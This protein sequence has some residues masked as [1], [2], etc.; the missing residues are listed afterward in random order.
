MRRSDLLAALAVA[1]LSLLVTVPRA[2]AYPFWQ[3]EVGAARVMVEP[4]LVEMLRGVV[5]TE[6]HPPGFYTFGWI[7]NGL[8]VPV[9][10]ARA[11]SVAAVAV[12]AAGVVL[13]ARRLMPLPFAALAGLAVALGWQFERHGWELRPYGLF[14]LV[15]FAAV[16]AL[17]WAARE[18]TLRRRVVLA[19]IVAVGSLVH[20]F[21]VFTLAAGVLWLFLSR[22]RERRAL[23][24]TIAVGL[25]P[26]AA[27][28]PAFVEQ[29]RKEHFAT[30]PSFH[31]RGVVD[32]YAD[33]LER[34]L[35]AG[36]LGLLVALAVLA[37]V[38]VGAV[39]LWA[40]PWRGRLCALA[41]LL[42]VAVAAAIWLGGPEIFQPRALIGVAPFA[43]ISLA[44]AL[45]TPGR[46]L[47]LAVAG[48]AAV[49][50]VAGFIDGSG[51]IVPD[52]DRVAQALEDEGWSEGSPILL[53]GPLYDY[54]HPLDWYLPG[55]ERLEA[56]APAGGRCRRA[57]V[58]SVGGRARALTA[59]LP[60]VRRVRGVVVG[61]V[62]WSASLWEEVRRRDGH[63]L[64]TTLVPC[65]R[66]L[67]SSSATE[68]SAP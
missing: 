24:A 34:S 56:A 33:L 3:D 21:F 60:Q 68:R 64:A 12:L 65:A 42:P 27:W 4:S 48:A 32:L 14:A 38:V 11:L 43:A 37:G 58:V 54:L 16:W 25:V 46:A 20:V 35:P 2:F 53:F 45:V 55:T 59:P 6:N 5:S 57:F 44:A 41:A 47:S 22:V 66:P 29:L 9:A 10:S 67:P 36:A 28:A 15:A 13:Y 17:E 51:R 1:A 7:V 31:V 62:P 19:G 18:P 8:G 26:L 61:S 50:L 63:V 39:R 52:Y 49:L 40:D 30:L 23:L